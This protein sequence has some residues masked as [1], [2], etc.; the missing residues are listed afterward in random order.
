MTD[1]HCHILPGMDDGAKNVRSAV[2]MVLSEY[3]Q[4]VRRIAL[5]SHFLPWENCIETFLEKRDGAFHRLKLAL[6]QEEKDVS[7]LEFRLGAE[8]LY[9]PEI[10]TLPIERLCLEGTDLLLLEFREQAIPFGLEETVFQLQSR[11]VVPILAHVERYPFVTEDPRWLYRWVAAGGFAQVN[12]GTII[13]GGRLARLAEDWM[14]WNLVHVLSSDAH[15]PH[16]RPPNLSEGLHAVER[17]LGKDAAQRLERH[18]ACLFS[19]A[20][21]EQEPIYMPKKSWRKWR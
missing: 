3:E 16:R 12:A 11:G 4:G 6:D 20:I 2:E 21:T 7:D 8:V 15:S 9:S 1:L 14:R 5:T 18:A 19:G 17:H 10:N 13:S